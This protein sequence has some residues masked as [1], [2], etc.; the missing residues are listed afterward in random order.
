MSDGN[1][2]VFKTDDTSYYDADKTGADQVEEAKKLLESAGY[3]F[4]DNG[5]G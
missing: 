3:T 4:T 1:G 5:D 2:G